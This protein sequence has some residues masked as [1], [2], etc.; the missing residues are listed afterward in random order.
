[1]VKINVIHWVVEE[2]KKVRLS[3]TQSQSGHG[4]KEKD[5]SSC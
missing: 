3:G 1:M 2:A 4:R 5:P